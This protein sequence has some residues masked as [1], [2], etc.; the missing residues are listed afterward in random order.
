MTDIDYEVAFGIAQGELAKAKQKIERL[1]SALVDITCLGGVD[2]GNP[3]EIK[4]NAAGHLECR[5]IARAAL[6][7]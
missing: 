5:R 1:R 6:E 4:L 2:S 7:V 3:S